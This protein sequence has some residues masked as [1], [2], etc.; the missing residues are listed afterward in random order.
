MNNGGTYTTYAVIE[1]GGKVL[2]E[3]DSFENVLR[4]LSGAIGWDDTR[5]R[6]ILEECEQSGRRLI[7]A[8]ASS[9]EDQSAWQYL[10]EIEDGCIYIG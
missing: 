10:G 8:Y 3:N 6:R 2:R 9:N 5:A 7:F 1:E 4:M